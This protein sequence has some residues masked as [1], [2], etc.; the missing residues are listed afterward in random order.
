VTSNLSKLGT[1]ST[2][3]LLDGLRK[4]FVNWYVLGPL[5]WVVL[6]S[7]CPPKRGIAALAGRTVT[8]KTRGGYLATCRINEFFSFVEVFIFREYDVPGIEWSRLRTIIDVGANVG[9]ATLWFAQRAP[10][11]RIVA[12]EPASSVTPLLARNIRANGLGGRVRLIGAALAEHSGSVD[13]HQTGSS[14]FGTVG[15]VGCDDGERV[16]AL[17]LEELLD[18]Y[19]LR[20]VDVLKLDCEG[21]EFGILLRSDEQTLR[22]NRVIVGEYHSPS[23]QDLNGLLARLEDAGFTTTSRGGDTLG[24]FRAVR[25]GPPSRSR[26]NTLSNV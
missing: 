16:R 15:P 14:V 1:P 21:A 3:R 11:S 4:E 13:I 5:A 23:R 22:R 17:T 24:L 12:V 8:V 20:E 6:P 19:E 18:R 25:F 7:R 2:R 9:A 26:V 10:Q